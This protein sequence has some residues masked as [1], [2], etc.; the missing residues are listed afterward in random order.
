MSKRAAELALPV[1]ATH[2][3]RDAIASVKAR[4]SGGKRGRPVV[5]HVSFR[6]PACASTT[7]MHK[8]LAGEVCAEE[9]LPRTS[10]P[11]GTEK[12][13]AAV[14]SRDKLLVT[15]EG[16]SHEALMGEGRL[17]AADALIAWMQTRAAVLP[18]AGAAAF[19]VAEPA[20]AAA[21]PAEAAA[22]PAEGRGEVA[23]ALVAC[24]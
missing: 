14:S 12:F 3:T 1:F 24:T 2:A 22:D 11:Q 15:V 6:N 20:A 13:M 5:L 8:H 4:C 21:A 17:A 19:E 9:P 18:A 7:R 23:A 16:A 10:H